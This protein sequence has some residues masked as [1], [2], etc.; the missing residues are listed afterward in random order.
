MK[1]VVS[2]MGGL[3]AGFGGMGLVV[4]ESHPL[5]SIYLITI[6]VVGVLVWATGVVIALRY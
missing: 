1:Y 2:V 4:G 3:M 5:G 6:L